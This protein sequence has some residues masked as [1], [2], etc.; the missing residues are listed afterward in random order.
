MK[1]SKKLVVLCLV[2]VCIC[3][4]GFNCVQV[5]AP[6]KSSTPEVVALGGSNG[7]VLLHHPNG[8]FYVVELQTHTIAE[9]TDLP[10]IP[11]AVQTY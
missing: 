9:V 6:Q 4:I 8:K 7:Y 10:T 2:L 11:K 1:V 5:V 3:I